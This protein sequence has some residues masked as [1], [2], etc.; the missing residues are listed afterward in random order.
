MRY[1]L[2]AGNLLAARLHYGWLVAA[3]VHTAPSR[4]SSAMIRTRQVVGKAPDLVYDVTEERLPDGQFRTLSIEGPIRIVRG[5]RPH[6]GTNRSPFDH[7]GHLIADQFGGPGAADS[8]NIVP[9]HGHPNNGAGGQF[10]AMEMT[11]E[12]LLG[13]RTAWMKVEVGYKEPADWRPHVFTV[14]VRFA[15]N[16]HSR[17]KIFNFSPLLPNPYLPGRR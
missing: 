6:S 15:N 3:R 16:M 17:W 9:M 8:G 1:C 4:R 7:H 10:R 2:I 12:R 14:Q 13:D 5:R 11:V